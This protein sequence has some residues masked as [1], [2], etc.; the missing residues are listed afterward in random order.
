MSLNKL[1]IFLFLLQ[2][3]L[4]CQWSDPAYSRI[5]ESDQES[6]R[7]KLMDKMS[8]NLKKFG[9]ISISRTGAV[10]MTRGSEVFK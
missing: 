8:I 10:A 6:E 9:L 5:S 7:Y 1:V 4:F 2:N 3:L